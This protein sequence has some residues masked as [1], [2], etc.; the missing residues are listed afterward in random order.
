MTQTSVEAR[1]RGHEIFAALGL[2]Q[3][4]VVDATGR[5]VSTVSCW[6][7]GKRTPQTKDRRALEKL[8]VPFESWDQP[9][10]KPTLV[11][12]PPHKAGRPRKIGNPKTKSTASAPSETAE[13]ASSTNGIVDGAPEPPKAPPAS[14]SVVERLTYQIAQ[15]QYEMQW[16]IQT[17]ASRSKL[18]ADEIRAMKERATFVES[19]ELSESRYLHKHPAWI[20]T[21]DT[22]LDA[23]KPH[24]AATR[25][26]IA[27]LHNL[28]ALE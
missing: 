10:L 2:R 11:L 9:P 23:L 21:R 6:R 4:E 5:A 14:A 19:I 12:P 1:S 20:V 24:P 3:K 13:P 7:S 28:G 22:I 17:T 26:V 27:A 15:I 16:T 8:G 18:R 25:D